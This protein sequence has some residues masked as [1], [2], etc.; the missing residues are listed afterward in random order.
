MTE[1]AWPNG[2]YQRT[3]DEPMRAGQEV[4]TH[5]HNF[6][7][8]TFVTNGRLRLEMLDGEDGNVVRGV[9]LNAASPQFAGGF[10]AA[11]TWHRLTALSDGVVYHC[12][13]V[14]RDPVTGDV[15]DVYTGWQDAY[16]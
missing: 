2:L 7:H 12:L 14:S 16:Q 11:D 8:W 5:R 13:Y 3:C 4:E 6:D 1:R 9:D 10:V 15:E